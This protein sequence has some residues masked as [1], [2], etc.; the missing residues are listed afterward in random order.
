MEIRKEDGAWDSDPCRAEGVIKGHL[1]C[2]GKYAW[3]HSFVHLLFIHLMHLLFTHPS[4]SSFIH[5]FI[6][7]ILIETPSMLS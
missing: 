5:S 3:T 1:T 2:V 4:I 6:H 7:H